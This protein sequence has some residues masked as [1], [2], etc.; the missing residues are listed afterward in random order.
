L[1][2]DDSHLPCTFQEIDDFCTEYKK[3]KTDDEEQEAAV[4]KSIPKYSEAMQYL[5]TCHHFLS[6]I[7]GM[8]ET[9]GN[10]KTLHKICLRDK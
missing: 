4:C 6:G 8:S 2:S 1:K 9:S 5:E 7:P 3:T 10:W